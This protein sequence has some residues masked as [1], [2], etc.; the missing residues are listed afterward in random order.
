MVI[1]YKGLVIRN[2]VANK[3]EKIYEDQVGVWLLIVEASV[4]IMTVYCM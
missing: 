3:R 1:E 2:E 4:C